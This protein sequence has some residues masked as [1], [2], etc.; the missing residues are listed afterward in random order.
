MKTLP[1]LFKNTVTQF[2]D[3]VAIVDRGRKVS[4]KALNHRVDEIATGLCR[5]GIQKGDRIGVWL[6]N[7][8]AYL[9][10]FLAAAKVGAIVISVNTKFKSH[11]MADIVGRSKCKSLILWPTFKNIPFLEILSEVPDGALR[12][13]QTVITY[14]EGEAL[15]P[16]PACLSHCEHVRLSDFD[17]PLKPLEVEAYP[18]DGLVVFTTSGTTGKPKFVLHTHESVSVHAV[19]VATH[20]GFDARACRLLQVNPLCGTF[21]LTQALAGLIS[22]ATVY[23][24]P[25]FDGKEAAD[26][27]QS[28]EITDLNGS[29]DM[30]H[31]ILKNT[32][33][34]HDFTRVRNAGFAAFNPTLGDLVEQAEEKKLRMMGLWGMSEV[35]AYVTHQ[36]PAAPADIRKKAGGRLISPDAEI[37]ITDPESGEILPIGQEGELEIRTPSQ[38]ICY[39]DNE[40][41]TAKTIT[42]D[43][44]VKTGDLCVMEDER[45]FTFLARMGDVLRLGGFLTDPVEIEDCLAAHETVDQAQVVAATTASG[46]RAVAFVILN[47]GETPAEGDLIAHCKSQLASF[48]VP[49]LVEAVTRFPTTESANGVK[50][51]RAKLRQMAEELIK[52]HGL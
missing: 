32:Q 18:E 43:G 51:Q 16:L 44:F 41:A 50:V 5:L 47:D 9:E 17:G 35:Q 38:M 34:D 12:N 36:D 46:S 15:P 14:D 8:T 3:R 42:R 11:E 2:P 39:L 30:Y 37:R 49:V 23:C 20:F 6:P 7:I 45:S 13:L 22:G 33:K 40:E 10:C 52:T 19:Q 24:V 48:K 25:V 4:Y 28:A 27:M 26:L 31:M 21:G 1:V 29:D